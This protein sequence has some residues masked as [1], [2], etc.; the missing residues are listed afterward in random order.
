MLRL[1][2]CLFLFQLIVSAQV[3]PEDRQRLLAAGK[4]EYESRCAAC[5]GQDANGGELGPSILERLSNDSDEEIAAVIKNGQAGGM[6][7]FNLPE[8]TVGNLISYLRVLQ[9]EADEFPVREETV[10]TTDGKTITGRVLSEGPNDLALRG[11][12]DCIYLLRRSDKNRY[13]L[14]TS[15]ADWS[16][17]H[18]QFNGNRYSALKQINKSNVSRL[19]PQWVFT[20]PEAA[21][22]E[23]TPLVVEGVMYVTSANQVYALDAGSGRELWHY[24]R[25][26]TK[27]LI[28]NA[29]GGINRGVAI[30]GERVFLATDNAHLIAINRFTGKLLWEAELADWHKNYQSTSAPLVVGNLVVS[31]VAGGDEGVRGVVAAFDQETGKE[32]WRFWTVPKPGE[33][34]SET[35]PAE[36]IEHS[37]GSTWFT[38]SYDPELDTVFWSAG[39][40]GPDFIGDKR[41]G[42][43][44]YT[45]STLALDAKTGKLKW[46]FQY[47]PHDVWDW[48]AQQPTVLLD[49]NWEGKPRK[50]LVQANRNGFYYVLDRTNGKLVHASP[51]VK[52]LTWARGI[53]PEGRPLVNPGQEPTAE[54]NKICPAVEGAANWFSTAFDPNKNLY[55]VQALESCALISSKPVEWAPFRAY[56]GGGER[57]IPGDNPQKFLRALDLRTG[58]IVWELPQHGYGVSWG[59][60]LATAGDLVFFCDDTGSFRAADSATGKPLWEFPGTEIWKASPMTYVFDNQQHVAVSSGSNIVSFALVK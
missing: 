19:A 10:Q 4:N 52:K 16:T 22:L 7:A 28:G 38:G 20:V 30:K 2:V 54:G 34:G 50:L 41:K 3:A 58:K 60:V 1:L 59:G 29:A 18:G 27:G 9:S 43:N 55:Y 33:A 35:W 26:R 40:P 36:A 13:R 53:S 6:P 46:Y 42:D 12:D 5:H 44:L 15:Q 48:D 21:H 49:A 23:V 57:R 11:K 24:R 56:Q 45:D 25:K 37:G 47:T 17:Y 14:V 51:F 8:K 39:N 31:G 32:A